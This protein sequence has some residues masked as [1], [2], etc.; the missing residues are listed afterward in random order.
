[1]EELKELYQP[2]NI[3]FRDEEISDISEKIKLYKDKRFV[4]NFII[5]GGSGS[6][7]TTIVQKI[8]EGSTS[9]F[10]YF[11]CA[12]IQ[13]S[14]RIF[15]RLYNA[16]FSKIIEKFQREPKIIIFD[17]INKVRD[18]TEF[19]DDINTF[20]RKVQ[21]PIILITNRQDI[22]KKM[23][24]DCRLTLFFE[25]VFLKSYSVTQIKQILESRLKEAE[26]NRGC[27]VDIL[28]EDIEG[29]INFISSLAHHQGSIRLAFR[30]LNECVEMDNFSIEFLEKVF[31]KIQ[32][33]ELYSWFNTLNETEKVVI[34]GLVEIPL[35]KQSFGKIPLEIEYSELAQYL[36]KNT[37]I[38]SSSRLSQ[39]L[40]KFQ[41][42]Y[43]IIKT[44]DE[45]LGR[46]GGKRKIISLVSSEN[47]KTLLKIIFPEEYS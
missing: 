32:R 35:S 21:S 13:S 33:E 38:Q 42:E 18:L 8:M 17:E 7:K 36:F 22:N 30:L 46:S 26:E 31:A 43:V 2:K 5:Y 27:K 10:I 4:T 20:Y 44:R 1:M 6:G 23:P 39:I 47:F 19:F 45:W 24:D 12:N 28:R 14:K 16:E 41:Y 29:A 3:L 34:K 37:P 15:R 11:S 25:K 40:W 9:D